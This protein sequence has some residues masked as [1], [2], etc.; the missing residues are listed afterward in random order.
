[1]WEE[2]PEYQKAVGKF[3]LG[4]IA[5]L[6]LLILTASVCTSNYIFIIG[7]FGGLLLFGIICI[8]YGLFAAGLAKTVFTILNLFDSKK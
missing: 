5:F 3:W 8:I 7:C 4:V 2:N 6:T 1:M